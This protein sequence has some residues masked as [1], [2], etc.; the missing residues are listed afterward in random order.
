[1]IGWLLCLALLLSP[2]PLLGVSLLVLLGGYHFLGPQNGPPV[3]AA[4]FTYQWL[5]ITIALLYF[6]LTGRQIVE[7]RTI[8]YKPIVLISLSAIVALFG[9]YAW[10][11]SRKNDETEIDRDGLHRASVGMVSI[12]YVVT[13]ALSI[14]VQRI[15]W[16]FPALTQFLF[17][18]GFARY[19]LLYILTMRLLNPT[20][21]WTL[22]L[23]V[24]MVELVLGFTGYFA[25]FRESL[26]FMGLAIV[27][28]GSLRRPSTWAAALLIAAIAFSAALTWTVIKPKVREQ[29]S[30]TSSTEDRLKNVAGVIA[31]ALG[32]T[33]VS[34]DYQLDHM[35][36]RL[37][38]V[39]YPSL[40]LARVP[41]TMPFEGGRILKSAVSNILMPRILFPE[42]GQIV[43]ESELVR[44]YT[45]IHV[46]G[47]DR[48]TS[49]AF[50]YVAESYVDFGWPMLLVPILLFGCVIGYCDRLIRKVIKNND[51]LQGVR[52]VV[53][54]SS[55]Y[56]FETSWVIMLGT[57]TSLMATLVVGA[58]LFEKIISRR[59]EPEPIPEEF[60]VA[61][62]LRASG[63][64]R[65]L[66]S[67][68][69]IHAG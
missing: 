17:V 9:G 69:R 23:F 48:G 26:V 62:H 5:Q 35:V 49:F 40:A 11:T 41:S 18:L 65:A 46:A 56:L 32:G 16:S 51:I 29:F 14:T 31:P 8:D 55:M 20:P 12:C 45:G 47:R 52:I 68:P 36:S 21:Q 28:S 37:W 22:V 6:A 67:D 61:N 34:W 43:S 25:S 58:Y 2:Q 15:A 27:A 7:M 50:G 13:L 60:L 19:A 66:P 4:A 54:W 24:L 64:Q 63:R 38:Q 39:Y 3:V 10:V 1:M 53:L 30:S 44:K 59:E 33:S 57:L 42:K